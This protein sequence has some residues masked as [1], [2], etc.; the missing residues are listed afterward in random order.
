MHSYEFDKVFSE[1]ATNQQV[2]E[3]TA[4]SLVPKV[5]DGMNCTIFAYGAT[6][7]GKILFGIG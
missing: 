2:Y 1:E 4:R 7:A 6:G 3:S 5:L